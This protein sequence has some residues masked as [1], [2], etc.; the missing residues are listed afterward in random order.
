MKLNLIIDGIPKINRNIHYTRKGLKYKPETVEENEKYLRASII[1]CLPYEFKPFNGALRI[2]L[3]HFVF[4][5]VPSLNNDEMQILRSGGRVI[6]PVKP[7]F[8]ECLAGLFRAL[9]G[10]VLISDA[11]ICEM[12]DLKRYYGAKPRI[13]MELEEINTV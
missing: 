13:E 12:S 2:N 9:Q 8:T 3:L 6:K 10:T 4:A 1:N 11:Q 7:D 5:P